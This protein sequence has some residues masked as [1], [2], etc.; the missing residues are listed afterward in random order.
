MFYLE[1]ALDREGVHQ[2]GFDN[3]FGHMMQELLNIE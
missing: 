2:G 3:T 1:K